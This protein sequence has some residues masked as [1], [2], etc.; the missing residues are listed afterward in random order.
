MCPQTS[1]PAG[2]LHGLHGLKETGETEGSL[3]CILCFSFS[4]NPCNRCN[5]PAGRLV[6]GQS[7]FPPFPLLSFILVVPVFRQDDMDKEKRAERWECRA[8]SHRFTLGR[9]A[10][11]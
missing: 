11:V 1:L 6:C 4:F 3:S 7:S 10:P 5:L 2:R 9:C 8:G